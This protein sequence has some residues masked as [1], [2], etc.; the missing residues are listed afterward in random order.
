MDFPKWINVDKVLSIFRQKESSN[1]RIAAIGMFDGVHRGHRF[2]IDFLKVEGSKRGLDATAVTFEQ[3]PL[4]L[5]RPESV[6]AMLGSLRQKMEWLRE[7]GVDEC[8]LLP[9]SDKIRRLSAREFLHTLKSTYKVDALVVGFNNHMG[10]DRVG[11]IEALR[12]I[13]E[14]IGMEILPAPEFSDPDVGRISSSVIRH[15]LVTGDLKGANRALG[16]PHTLEGVVVEGHR[17]GRRLGY[18]TANIHPSDPAVQLPAPG[19]YAARVKMAD[20]TVHNGMVN[21]GHRPTVDGNDATL[22]IEVNIF[23]FLGYLY[24]ETLE[25]EFVEFMRSEKRFASI[26]K[27]KQAIAADERTARRILAKYH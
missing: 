23:D 5:V 14:A 17:L 2:L 19:V 10:S 21:I 4:T 25:V 16:H 7:A 9:F 12:S 24:G 3:H 27:L 6:P 1:R 18:P 22:S 11:D 13:G 15:M 20:G 8:V 26:D